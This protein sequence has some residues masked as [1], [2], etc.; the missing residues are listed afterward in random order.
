[1]RKLLLIQCTV[2]LST[3]FVLPA[4]CWGEYDPAY[5]GDLALSADLIATGEIVELRDET[6]VFKI[7]DVLVGKRR[8]TIEVARFRNWPCAWRWAKYEVGERL[9]IFVQERDGKLDTIGA[10]CEGECPI[11]KN[12]VYCSFSCSLEPRKKLG[13]GEM[14]VVPLKELRAAILD[15]RSCY[16]LA[17]P[18]GKAGERRD[19]EAVVSVRA[20]KS[21]AARS[22]MHEFAVEN[23]RRIQ[24][25]LI[26]TY[27]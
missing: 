12:D 24:E 22:K 14:A 23:T 10:A 19:I 16:R 15:Y 27:R 9:L 17:K 5:F 3:L 1:M 21:F 6:Y 25:R 8:D 13:K 11:V 2:L 4:Y 7:D 20:L 26:K 18:K